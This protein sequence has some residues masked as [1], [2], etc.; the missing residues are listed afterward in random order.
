M[1]TVIKI[2]APL[3]ADHCLDGFDCGNPSL[4]EWLARYALIN[5]LANAARTFVVCD[6]FRVIGFYSLAVGSV[7][8]EEAQPRIKKGIARHPIPI[9]I[10]AR[11]AVDKT[12]HGR[13]VGTGLLKDALLRAVNI[14]EQAGVRAVFVNAKDKR[15][16]S[17]YEKHG[18]ESSLVDSLSLMLLIKD[19]KRSI[20]LQPCIS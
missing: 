7:Q 13:N 5:Q 17:F 4:N 16:K 20:A 10:L 12:H 18:F 14:S 15:A 6:H 19:I 11:L 1:G 2:P 8:Y 9:M 3:S